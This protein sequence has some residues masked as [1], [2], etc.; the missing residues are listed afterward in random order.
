MGSARKHADRETL[1]WQRIRFPLMGL[2]L[3]ALLAALHISLLLRIAGDLGGWYPARQWGGL[4]NA[5][6][7][8]FF[9][10]NTVWMARAGREGI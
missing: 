4:L 9:L 8:L 7:L 6:A 3:L 1:I 5:L 2:A 10:I